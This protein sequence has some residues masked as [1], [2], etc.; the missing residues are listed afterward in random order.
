MQISV[1]EIEDK[2]DV[3]I[4][5]SSNHI[6]Q[7]NNVFVSR[8]FLQEND[9]SESSLGVRRILKRI[10]V[11]FQRH[12]FF[13]SLVN[14]FPD[15]AVCTFTYYGLKKVGHKFAH[16]LENK[17]DCFLAKNSNCAQKLMKDR[18]DDIFTYLIFVGFRTF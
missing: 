4:I 2:V 7:S 10:K 1:H 18:K 12:N 17:W 15:D 5:F 13:R 3:P 16:Q 8:Q 14:C 6:L 11:L 9:F